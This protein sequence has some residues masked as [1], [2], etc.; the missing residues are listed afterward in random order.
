VALR[1]FYPVRG[2]AKAL[3]INGCSRFFAL[4]R[5]QKFAQIHPAGLII[6][7]LK[8]L[9]TEE[10][11][12]GEMTSKLRTTAKICFVIYIISLAVMAVSAVIAVVNS[13]WGAFDWSIGAFIGFLPVYIAI[14]AK[15]EK[16]DDK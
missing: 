9:K 10:R 2:A 7:Y 13:G 6:A 11:G 12:C 1:Y 15:D 5:G 4:R 3:S 14:F 16:K 8:K